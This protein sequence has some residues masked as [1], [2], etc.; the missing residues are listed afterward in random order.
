MTEEDETARAVLAANALFYRAFNE[1]DSAAMGELWAAR[2]P[3]A[4]L[5]PGESL[6]VGRQQVL[7]RWYEILAS[8]PAFK[9]RCERPIVQ[10]FGA[11]AIVYCYEG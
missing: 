7:R 5:H 10:M 4:C 3:V 11:T 9:L 2:S 8:R 6:I 1:R